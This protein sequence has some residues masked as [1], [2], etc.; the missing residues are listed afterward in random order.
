MININEMVMLIRDP[1]FRGNVSH[2][3]VNSDIRSLFII[4]AND[5]LL[6]VKRVEM[7][8]LR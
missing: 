1:D 4:L 7:E 8:K 6:M 3:D 2:Y 5:K